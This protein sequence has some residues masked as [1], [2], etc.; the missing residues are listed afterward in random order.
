MTDPRTVI[1][2]LARFVEDLALTLPILSGVD[3]KDASVIPMPLANWRAVDVGALRVA[4]YTY[5]EGAEP[6]PETAQ[7]CR[8][9]AHVLADM[10]ARVDE[11]L[12]PRIEEA[13]HIT[14]QYW[15]RAE[16]AAPDEYVAGGEIKLT[17]L[18]MEQHLFAW[19][20]FRRALI[21]FVAD[22]DVILTPAAEQPATPHGT[23]GGWIPYTLPYSLT[24]WP[25]VVVRAGTT[26]EGLPIGVQVVA[27]PWREDVA[28][29]VAQAIER[30]LG[31][32]EP[33]TL[34]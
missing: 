1:G 31:G 18:E 4:T 13:S 33:P 8:R 3:W 14:R 27:R 15:Q 12:P 19:D 6:T 32:W 29:A 26:P 2:P 7:T 22:F 21:G 23:G 10:G 25:C 20:R 34:D 17:S 9:A 16:S 11:A 5:H 24:G 28:L 30:A